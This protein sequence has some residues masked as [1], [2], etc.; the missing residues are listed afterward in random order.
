[1]NGVSLGLRAGVLTS[2]IGPN[3]AGKT[4]LVNL[5]TGNVACDAGRVLFEGTDITQL[6]AHERVRTGISRS[7]QITNIFLQMTVLQNLQVPVLARL[8]RA[9]RPFARPDLDPEVQ[10]EV[11][12]ILRDVGLWEVRDVRASALPHGEQRLLEIGMAI[13]SRPRLCFLDEPCSGMNPA[14]RD[15]VQELIRELSSKH[16][17]TFVIVEHD[18]DMVFALSDW[19]VV[20][21]QGAILTEG[22][23]QAIR[24]HAEVRE[25]YLG[26]KVG[27]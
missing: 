19:I 24:S 18:M 26:E 27:G 23:P 25:I 12:A 11:Q 14:E 1:M 3:G 21:H 4:T 17:V 9:A 5:F 10:P 2:I 20:M 22:D 6:P 16:R 8:Q 13:A 15:K 7:F